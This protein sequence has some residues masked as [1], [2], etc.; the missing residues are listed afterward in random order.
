MHLE[1]RRL[2]QTPIYSHHSCGWLTLGPYQARTMPGCDMPNE[3]PSIRIDHPTP[4]EGQYLPAARGKR[5]QSKAKARRKTPLVHGVTTVARAGDVEFMRMPRHR[6]G[7]AKLMLAPWPGPVMSNIC[8]PPRHRRG[9][10][11]QVLPAWHRHRPTRL[12]RGYRRGID[13]ARLNRCYLRAMGI[14]RASSS[15]SYHRGR[16]PVKLSWIVGLRVLG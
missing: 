8:C 16:Y 1:R 11:E 3:L 7:K 10:D 14:G 6:S 12:G 15:R 13:Q 9:E 5:L 4:P 2:P